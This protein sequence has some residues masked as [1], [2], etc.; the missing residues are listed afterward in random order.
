[1]PFMNALLRCV[2]TNAVNQRKAAQKMQGA[3]LVTLKNSAR[4]ATFTN[5]RAERLRSAR[6]PLFECVMHY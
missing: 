4:V 3:T 2:D 1:M 5:P 6:G